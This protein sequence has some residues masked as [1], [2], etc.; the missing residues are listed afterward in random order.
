MHKVPFDV[1][2]HSESALISAKAIDE[3]LLRLMDVPEESDSMMFYAIHT[4][5]MPVINELNTAMEIH[6]NNKAHHTG[7]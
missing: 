6:K 2:V 5:L 1:L 4:L 7:E 3:L